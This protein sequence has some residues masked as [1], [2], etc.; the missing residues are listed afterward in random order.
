MT[1]NG[2]SQGRLPYAQK[3]VTSQRLLQNDGIPKGL[4]DNTSVCGGNS[5]CRGLSQA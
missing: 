1:F 3:S 4:L 5:Y 2:M